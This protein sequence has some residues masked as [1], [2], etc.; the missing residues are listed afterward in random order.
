[1]E[2][3]SYVKHANDDDFETAVLKA[4]RPTL[5]DFWAPWCGPCRAIGPVLEEIAKDY[6]EKANVV[7]VNVDECPKTAEKFKIRSIPTLLLIRDGQVREAHI[8]SGSKERL[9]QLIDKNLG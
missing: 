6:G 9:A 5:V 7:K 3:T 8:G 2:T 4:D 1:M